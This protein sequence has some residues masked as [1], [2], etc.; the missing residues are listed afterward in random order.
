[1]TGFKKVWQQECCNEGF[2]CKHAVIF[3]QVLIYMFKDVHGRS[4]QL[5]LCFTVNSYVCIS[6]NSERV[7]LP[8]LCNAEVTCNDPSVSMFI[9]LCK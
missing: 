2:H 1:M 4:M 7:L 3:F 9:V 8:L 6:T 5:L